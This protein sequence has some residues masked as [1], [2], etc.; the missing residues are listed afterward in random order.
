MAASA[1]E[2]ALP[3]AATDPKRI[4]IDGRKAES[5]PLPDLIAADEYLTKKSAGRLK[6]GGVLWQQI[7]PPGCVR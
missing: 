3:T 4:E 7:S 6:S 5:H 2:T 1:I